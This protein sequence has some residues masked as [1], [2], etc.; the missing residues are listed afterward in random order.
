MLR[1]YSIINTET[2][3]I[4]KLTCTWP[5]EDNTYYE[6]GGLSG[7]WRLATNTEVESFSLP[8]ET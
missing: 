4:K 1:T 3:E 5:L 8:D 6:F 7:F 2:Q